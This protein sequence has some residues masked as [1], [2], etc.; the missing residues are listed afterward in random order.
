VRGFIRFASPP[1]TSGCCKIKKMSR[2]RILFVTGRLAEP[3][4][5][6]VLQSMA[7][8]MG[9]DYDVAVLEFPSRP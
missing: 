8:R 6:T 3:S 7:D 5:R 9:F 4:L 1:S 2:E